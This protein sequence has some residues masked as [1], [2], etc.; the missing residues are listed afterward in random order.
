LTAMVDDAL[1]GRAADGA[2]AQRVHRTEPGGVPTVRRIQPDPSR[3]VPRGDLIERALDVREEAGIDATSDSRPEPAAVVLDDP[4]GRVTS[5]G[6]EPRRPGE[7]PAQATAERQ[8]GQRNPDLSDDEAQASVVL[9]R[10]E[11]VQRR[12]RVAR[13][14]RGRVEREPE[15]VRIRRE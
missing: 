6:D 11:R 15:D 13:G 14:D 2:A 12:P 4:R 5:H 10:Y 1:L 9:D 7:P 8:R 3:A